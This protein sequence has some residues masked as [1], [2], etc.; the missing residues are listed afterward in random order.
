MS[1]I[2]LVVQGLVSH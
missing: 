1:L 2:N